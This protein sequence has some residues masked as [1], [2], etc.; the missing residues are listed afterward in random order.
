[1]IIIKRQDD[2][3]EPVLEWLIENVGSNARPGLEPVWGSPTSKKV[4]WSAANHM[5]RVVLDDRNKEIS[6]SIMDVEKEN[7]LREH[8][9]NE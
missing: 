8:L 7:L 4:E 3:F 1:M 2:N 5:W 9:N 6:I